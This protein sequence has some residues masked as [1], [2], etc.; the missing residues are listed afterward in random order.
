MAKS[1]TVALQEPITGHK[2]QITEVKVKAPGLA[3]YQ[4][5]GDPFEFVRAGSGR[6][7]QPVY[8]EYNEAIDAYLD[9][10]VELP[11]GESPLLKDQIGLLDAMA[12]KDA[13]LGFF[14]E[15]R[16]ALVSQTS[17]TSSS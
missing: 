9:A 15:A 2:G 17:P 10:C 4:R 3:L 5:H 16:L 7:A 13:L 14:G 8:V 6:K 11:A 12:I 1:V